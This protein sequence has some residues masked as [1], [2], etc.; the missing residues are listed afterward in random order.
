LGIRQ[1][2]FRHEKVK[3][4]KTTAANKKG[5]NALCACLKLPSGNLT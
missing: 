5:E 2:F 4:E 3:T 1:T